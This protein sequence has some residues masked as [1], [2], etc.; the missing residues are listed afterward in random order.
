[1]LML[2]QTTETLCALYRSQLTPFVQRSFDALR[3]RKPFHVG[4]HIRAICYQ[5]ERVE[6][7]DIRN[8]MILMPPRHGKSHCVSVAFPVWLMGRDPTTRV[9]TISYG[10]VLADRFSRESRRLM[11]ADFVR[12]CFPG[13]QIDRKKA[14]VEELL[15][16]VGGGR[17]AT[18]VGGALT[19]AGGDVLILDDPI[20]ADEVSSAVKRE[21]VWNWYWESARSR[22]DR[23]EKGA[24]IL[25]AQR[26]HQDDL[27]GRLMASGEWEVLELPAIETVQ[28]EVA[29]GDDVAWSRAPG[30]VLLPEHMGLAALESIRNERPD[31]FEAQYQQ[32][33]VPEGG[34]II[35]PEWFGTYEGKPKRSAYEGI[36]QSWDTAHLPGD[37]NDYS[38]CTTWGLTGNHIDLLDLYRSRVVYPDLLDAALNLRQ[39]WKPQ[40]IAIELASSGLSLLPD[41]RRRGVTETF[42]V[43]PGQGKEV[44]MSRQSVLIKSGQVRLPR[45]APWREAFLAEVVAFPHGAYDDQADSLSLA[46]FTVSYRNPKLMRCSRYKE[47]G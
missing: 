24:T 37:S 36:L 38:V 33:P 28:R 11:E 35:R 10:S 15:T 42:G 40:V 34:F 25:V 6:R 32:S 3:P 31:I 20:K 44:R 22:L 45:T 14:S 19:G 8:L 30:D 4:H 9:V 47:G 1:M 27:P 17:I 16:T 12:A 26:L 2:P 43:Q 5:L 41:L 29:L 39:T 7:G 23:P 13:L 21:A 46:L 18:S